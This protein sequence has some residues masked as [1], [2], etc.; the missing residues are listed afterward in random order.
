MGVD[1][2][3]PKTRVDLAIVAGNKTFMGHKT[4][5]HFLD[6]L[7]NSQSF[8]GKFFNELCGFRSAR[9]KFFSTLMGQFSFFVLHSCVYVN[10]PFASTMAEPGLR[11][12]EIVFW[13]WVST[14]AANEFSQMK[15]FASF[16]EYALGSGNMLDMLISTF[17]FVSG[18]CRLLT[19]IL[20]IQLEEVSEDIEATLRHVY[21]LGCV[22][23]LG[24]NLI[25]TCLRLLF[26]I[27]V[28]SP[29]GVLLIIIGRIMFNDLLPF[30]AILSIVLV[31][32]E[33]F[34]VFFAFA[35]EIPLTHVDEMFTYEHKSASKHTQ[36]SAIVL[37]I[38][39]TSLGFVIQFLIAAT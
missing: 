29:V 13:A 21:T 24:I 22:L 39:L 34:G 6:Q 25:L 15:D 12:F 5:Q 9:R 20:S 7:W 31:S 37:E 33:I 16:S 8:N 1:V 23:L 3:T 38:V 27:S 4:T 36:T 18:S 10:M 28:W 11:W 2:G 17:F 14:I 19:G 32:F 35:M 30:F 26:M